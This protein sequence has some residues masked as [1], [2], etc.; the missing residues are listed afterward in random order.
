MFNKGQH[1]YINDTHNRYHGKE[2][3]VVGAYGDYFD[4]Q[5]VHSLLMRVVYEQ[6]ETKER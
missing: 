6:L 2:A 3:V 1:I 5:I 4:V